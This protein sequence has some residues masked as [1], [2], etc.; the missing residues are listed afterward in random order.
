[1]VPNLKQIF[2]DFDSSGIYSS[3]REFQGYFVKQF[4][5]LVNTQIEKLYLARF[6]YP[7]LVVPVYLWCILSLIC[8]WG[9]PSWRWAVSLSVSAGLLFYSY[10]HFW[11]FCVLA[12]I[13]SFLYTLIFLRSD[14]S[15]VKK[16]VVSVLIL[17]VI[18]SPYF[19]NFLSF[20]KVVDSSYFQRLGIAAGRSLGLATLGYDYSFY[21]ILSILI[22]LFIWKDGTKDKKNYAVLLWIFLIS[23]VILW[24]VQVIT[25]FVPAPN[26]WKRTFSPILYLIIF[27]LLHQAVI[28]K[29]SIFKPR[30]VA[31]VL[32]LLTSLV[33]VKKAVNIIDIFYYPE[34]RIIKN[35]SFSNN[36]LSSWNWINNNLKD[37]PK[38]VSDSFLTSYYL[39]A[40][41]SSRPFLPIG[42]ATTQST[43][44]IEER[45]LLTNK[46]FN[47]SANTIVSQLTGDMLYECPSVGC[48]DLEVNAKKNKWFMYFH[49]FRNI[50][51]NDYILNPTEITPEYIKNMAY[52]YSFLKENVSF[53]NIDADYVYFGPWEKQFSSP[54]FAH[55]KFL[56]PVFINESVK[57][58]KKI[59]NNGK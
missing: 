6:D 50:P 2:S 59:D 24:N 10:F 30:K 13:L 39:S 16:Y 18:A 11:V 19:I 27:S 44:A 56:I 57:I 55:N 35:Y 47:V 14:R 40:Y 21:I 46:L 1:M 20:S 51:F 28:K 32:F 8:F 41:T 43:R 25:G 49:F 54:D 9:K 5:P 17:I 34:D 36:I 58:Y 42:N 26:N 38:I 23:M 12:I 37:E 15:M 45:Y 33:L 22:Y 4:W 52:R 3:F 53:S 29:E 48:S 31:L 7:L